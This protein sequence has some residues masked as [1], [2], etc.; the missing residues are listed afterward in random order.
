[1]ISKL[2][3]KR[4]NVN[5][6]IVV[7][8]SVNADVMVGVLDIYKYSCLYFPMGANV[9]LIWFYLLTDGYQDVNIE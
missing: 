4:Y 9:S 1:M 5:F 3:T 7:V 2:C 6:Y 8:F